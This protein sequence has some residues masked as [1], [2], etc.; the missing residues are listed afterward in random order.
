M[1]MKAMIPVM[2]HEAIRLDPHSSAWFN[3]RLVYDELQEY[4]LAIRYT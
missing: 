4:D 1:V 3:R 2:P